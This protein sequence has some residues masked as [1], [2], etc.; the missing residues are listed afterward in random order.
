M[1]VVVAVDILF[2]VVV[3]VVVFVVVVVVIVQVVVF[4]IDVVTFG[5][6]NMTHGYFESSAPLPSQLCFEPSIPS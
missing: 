4:V 1:I 5:T 6:S 2:V 3:V